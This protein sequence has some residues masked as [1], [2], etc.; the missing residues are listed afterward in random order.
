M[1]TG[2][3]Q[4]LIALVQCLARSDRH[5][6]TVSVNKY[7]LYFRPVNRTIIHNILKEFNPVYYRCLQNP[8]VG[9]CDRT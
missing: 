2:T 8:I 5:S 7:Q 4:R 6:D 1:N 3:E 9:V